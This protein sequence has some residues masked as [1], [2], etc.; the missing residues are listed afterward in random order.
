MFGKISNNPVLINQGVKLERSMSTT[1]PIARNMML[2][3]APTLPGGLGSTVSQTGQGGTKSVNRSK[4]EDDFEILTDEDT[5]YGSDDYEAET[6]GLVKND[7]KVTKKTNDD[8][9][10]ITE[11]N[12]DTFEDTDELQN[13]LRDLVDYES[14][15]KKKDVR[16]NE[17]KSDDLNF[18]T[19]GRSKSEPVKV[20]TAKKEGSW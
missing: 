10:V 8:N 20:S 18:E 3:N 17:H 14:K 9:G 6:H 16:K 12:E 1:I 11:D 4:Q 15:D 7:A 2:K 13:E 19:R 5:E